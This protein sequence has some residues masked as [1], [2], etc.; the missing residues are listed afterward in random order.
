MTPEES[1]TPRVYGITD[2]QKAK[3]IEI[4]KA[5]KVNGDMELNVTLDFI[6]RNGRFHVNPTDGFPEIK[7]I[8]KR[9]QITLLDV[10]HVADERKTKLG[11]G[12]VNRDNSINVVLD[13]LPF[14]GQLVL[15]A[16][17]VKK[18]GVQS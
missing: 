4:G 11:I 16:R 9:E 13:A 7:Q 17:E 6:P 1:T 10:I 5:E 15:R 8:G 3:W 2:D 14:T 12:F 18:E